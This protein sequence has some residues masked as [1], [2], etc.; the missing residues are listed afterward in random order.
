MTKLI[1]LFLVPFLLFF[2]LFSFGQDSITSHKDAKKEAAFK[3][4]FNWN[5]SAQI[6]LRHSNLND[7]SL[8]NSEP[9]SRFTDVSIR[10]IRIP[11]SSQITP[12]IYAAAMFGGNNY[13]L[14][15]I[16][17]PIEILDFYV[18][19]AFSKYLEIGIGKSGWQGLSRWDIRSASTLMGLDTPLFTL[20]TVEKND[21]LGRQ[22][23]LWFKGQAN[24]LD[25][26]LSIMQPSTISTAPTGKVDFA[27]NKP[28]WKTSAYVKYQFFE[29]E[30]NK[31]AY[32]I[33]TY[34]A[35]K[36]VFNIGTGF[37]FQEKAFSDIDANNPAA[38]LYDMKHWA[39]DTFLNLPLANQNGITAYLGF[40]DFNFGKD[41]IRNVGANNP[42]NGVE[43]GGFNG[44]GVAFPMIG[45]GTTWFTQLGYT[46]KQTNLFNHQTVIQP[47]IAIQHAHW[48]ALADHMTVYDFTVNFLVNGS[49]SNKISLGYQY[50]P[51]FDS[52]T[53]TN[54][55]YKGMTVLQYQ[56][57]LK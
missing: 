18:E 36:K 32:Q 27:N 55:N 52:A 10:R 44:A 53:L 12:K 2:S 34:L 42:T 13:N 24:H 49:H 4:T 1:N 46:F 22:Y 11:V 54:T 21:D 50:R 29:N 57:A 9:T 33:G 43:N 28:R 15:T 14:K 56:I 37:Q 3:P 45:T 17:N 38:T 48:D 6:W 40:Y 7:G 25:Y 8:V 20:N 47:N 30:S 41:Y 39:I 26:R 35:N 19:Y 31:S 16:D 5:I 23:G 51:I